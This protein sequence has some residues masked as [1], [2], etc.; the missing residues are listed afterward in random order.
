MLSRWRPRAGHGTMT[1]K[2]V[3]QAVSR[4]RVETKE[5]C[6]AVVKRNVE[7]ARRIRLELRQLN[8]TQRPCR[9]IIINSLAFRISAYPGG[10]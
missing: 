4:K 9:N 6:W 10:K 7:G 3:P 1:V 8:Q 5:R 2:T